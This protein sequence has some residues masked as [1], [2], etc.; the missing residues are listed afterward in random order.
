MVFDGGIYPNGITLTLEF[1]ELITMD[2]ERY[3]KFV[4]IHRTDNID[5]LMGANGLGRDA[6]I[7]AN[8]L[9]ANQKPPPSTE[10][11]EETTD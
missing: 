5:N 11:T 9:E 10:T 8:N 4:S 2:S 7:M 6:G 1:S 3:K